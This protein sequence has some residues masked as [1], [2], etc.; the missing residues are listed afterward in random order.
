MRGAANE[1]CSLLDRTIRAAKLRKVSS[2]LNEHSMKCKA[3]PYTG[4]AVPW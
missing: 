2:L 4:I 1:K 3:M